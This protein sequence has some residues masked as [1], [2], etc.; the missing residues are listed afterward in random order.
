MPDIVREEFQNLRMRRKYRYITFKL[1]DDL[2]TVE[3]ETLG[4]RT[5][6]WDDFKEKTT[7][8]GARWI[9]Y[10]LEFNMPDGRK[11][12]KLCFI[13]YSPDDNTNA[14]E[15]FSVAAN[16]DAIKSKISEVNR[17]FQINRWDAL[18]EGD[19]TKVFS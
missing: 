16:K 19:F 7:K 15:K 4:A 17:D 9:V 11:V 2:A 13:V 12:S 5:E 10:D 8:T 14:G 6:T 1:S 18:V 3:V